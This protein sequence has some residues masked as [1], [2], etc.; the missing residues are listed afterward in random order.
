MTIAQIIGLIVVLVLA[1]L[2]GFFI[3][4]KS[5]KN[6][7]AKWITL[8]ILVSVSLT[9]IFTYGYFSGA[10]Y[11]DYGMNQQGIT[12][13]PNLVYYSINFAG[14]KIVFLLALGAFYAVLSKCSGYKKLVATV[15][16]KLKGKEI[17]VTLVVS[18][19]FTAMASLFT[20]TFISLVFVP[21]VI[22]VLL[23]M[24]LDKI[25]AF[26]VTFG[27]ILIGTLG[28]TYG[29][30]GAYWFNYY[31]QTSLTT[32]ILYRLIVLVVSF[33]LFNFF[34]IMH[35]R[36]VLNGKKVNEIEDDPFKVEKLD[37]KAKV[38]PNI[39]LFALLFVVIVLGY[40]DWNANFGISC[41]NDFHNWLL[42]LK[43]GDFEVFKAILGTLAVEAP[44]GRWNLFH[45]SIILFI[46]SVVSALINRMSLNDFIDSF[47]EGCKKMAKPL[48][49]YIGVYMVMVAAYMS[50]FIPTITNII[51]K[52]VDA[53][54][55][56]L[57]AFDAL[58]A[59]TF[60]VDFGFT[61]Y[62]VATYFT[63][64]FGANI[65]AI[66]T[67]FST[68][69]GFAGLCIPT[70]GLLLIGLSYLDI[71]YKTWIKYIWIFVLA[72]LVILLALFAII[73]YV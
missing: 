58:L 64:T 57:V 24:K 9:W 35:V 51:F 7:L 34:T 32:G 70:S 46:I 16:E 67:I 22:S 15:A 61:G 17:I 23:Q 20:Q 4:K 47:G 13:I 26:C 41:F 52:N 48:A 25:T 38:W 30:E 27:S 12:D 21:F 18:L 37:K 29:G 73:T 19:L 44:F 49:L 33:L 65:E 28:V 3:V 66:H 60:H 39:V 2:G 8:F 31:V 71:D 43:I 14:D 45:M 55:P 69:Y 62:V 5:K 54:N 56:F 11:N 72:I 10:T 53:F 1:A 6:D 63:T 50:P 42:G 68:M 40:I 59:N 36:K